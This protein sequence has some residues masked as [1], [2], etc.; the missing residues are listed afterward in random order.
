MKKEIPAFIGKRQ[1][2]RM[3][4]GHGLIQRTYDALWHVFPSIKKIYHVH[5]PKEKL[6]IELKNG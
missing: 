4:P 3:D 1:V 6:V 5:S 2:Y